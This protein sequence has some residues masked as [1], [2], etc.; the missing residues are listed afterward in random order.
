MPLYDYKCKEC[1]H[2]FEGVSKIEDR[3]KVPCP[4]CGGKS[5]L[6]ITCNKRDWFKPSIWEDFTDHPIEVTS[7]KH[8]KAL[9]KEH[10][11]YARA[12]D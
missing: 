8:L 10:G 2:E 9:C 7:K 5:D 12:L 11:V 3:N 6:L 4:K 1:H